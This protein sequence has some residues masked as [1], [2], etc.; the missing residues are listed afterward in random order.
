MSQYCLKAMQHQFLSPAQ[1]E[2]HPLC[3]N[4]FPRTILLDYRIR[5]F[6]LK[7]HLNSFEH[8]KFRF[9]VSEAIS[10]I[11]NYSPDIIPKVI[12]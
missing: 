10:S 8:T 2:P 4:L 3:K 12:L 9:E 7:N 1:K 11:M 5:G 6:D